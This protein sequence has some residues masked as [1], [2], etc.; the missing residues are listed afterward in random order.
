MRT[1]NGSHKSTPCCLYKLFVLLCTPVDPLGH[2]EKADDD[3]FTCVSD[4]LGAKT[5]DATDVCN[6][7]GTTD[8]GSDD[9]DTDVCINATHALGDKERVDG[10][11]KICVAL[12]RAYTCAV[13]ETCNKD[14]TGKDAACLGNNINLSYFTLGLLQLV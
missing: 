13:N 4:T 14:G 5:C 1:H 9:S 8:D 11:K 2:G 6:K 10:D 12:D 7:K 3:V